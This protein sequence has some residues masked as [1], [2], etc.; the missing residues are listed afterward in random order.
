MPLVVVLALVTRNE[1]LF[2]SLN[3]PRKTVL[4]RAAFALKGMFLRADFSLT[5]RPRLHRISQALVIFFN[6]RS[7][8]DRAP[9]TV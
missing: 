8:T 2:I 5:H 3:Q 7:D 4:F 1:A 6:L 9:A